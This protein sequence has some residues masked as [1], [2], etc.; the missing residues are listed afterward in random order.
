VLGVRLKKIIPYDSMTVYMKR[1]DVLAAEFTTGDDFRLFSSLRIPLG[2]GLA[3]WVADNRKPIVNGNPSVEPGYLND[4]AK[5]STLRSGLAVPLEG[6]SGVVGVIALYRAE[7]D[8]FT[9]DHLRVLLAIGSKLGLSLENSLRFRQ[10]EDNATIDFLTNLPNARSLF[11]HLEQEIA[12][13]R[14]ENL[15]L[16][17]VVGDLDGFKEINDRWGHLEGNR[18]LHEVATGLRSHCR[19]ND[20]VA[21]MGGDEFVIVMP[22]CSTDLFEELAERFQCVAADAGRMV[23]GSDLLSISLGSTQLDSADATADSLLAEADRQMYKAKRERRTR[24]KIL[25]I[26]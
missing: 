14:R 13:C 4:P 3:G 11:L 22:G 19:V 2:Q 15:P 18:V 12:R 1:A 23:G 10:A 16:T 5:F 26:A 24:G 7:K 20:Y 17:V 25:K 8:A 6:L 9:T 21:R